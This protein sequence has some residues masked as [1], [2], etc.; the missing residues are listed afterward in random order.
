MFI[1]FY[2]SRDYVVSKIAS[3]QE[4]L[5]IEIFSSMI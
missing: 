1:V 2:F 5:V 3:C 4:I